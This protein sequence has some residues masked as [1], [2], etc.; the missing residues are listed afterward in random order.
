MEFTLDPNWDR[1]LYFILSSPRSGSSVLRNKLDYLSEAV[2]LPSDTRI[3]EFIVMNQRLEVRDLKVKFKEYFQLR[4][5]QNIAEPLWDAFL[6]H[7]TKT[8]IDLLG[9]TFVLWSLYKGKAIKENFCL[10]EKSPIHLNYLK[11]I[12]TFFPK[13][14][15][16]HLYRDPRSVVSSLNLATWSTHN[17][18]VNARRWRDEQR[19]LMGATPFKI[20]Y[21]DLCTYPKE[22]MLK[23]L[24]FI[25]YSKMDELE[26]ILE[27][28][29]SEKNPKIA[30][31]GKKL[32]VE[33]IE[34]YKKF[35]SK[36]DRDLE[37]VEHVCTKE[38]KQMGYTVVGKTLMLNLRRC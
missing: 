38:M 27:V 37:L 15:L 1:Q 36:I 20:S 9:I 12:Q 13:A 33:S 24:E 25:G 17:T 2:V 7:A 10:I 31:S 22:S 11:D 32:D 14:K 34:K 23:V 16:I 18:Y 29:L 28:D 4:G 6:N 30:K 8:H 5:F 19:I 21:E 3:V 26:D 35:F